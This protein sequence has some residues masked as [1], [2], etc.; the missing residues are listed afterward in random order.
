MSFTNSYK[1]E[2]P[3]PSGYYGL[4]LYDINWMMP[5]HGAT[6]ESGR[7]KLTPF[8][9]SLHARGYADQAKAHPDSHRW[10][11]FNLST[12]DN[13]LT[14][15]ETLVRRNPLAILFAVIDQHNHATG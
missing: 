1:A 2:D 6:L 15:V 14:Q 11:P 7:V 10:Y 8:V 12:L 9:P 4:D 13:I 5:L 3:L